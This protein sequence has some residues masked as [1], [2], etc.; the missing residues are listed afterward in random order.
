MKYN[1]ER[2]INE[3]ISTRAI[4][5]VASSYDKESRS[6]LCVAATEN[7]VLVPDYER[8][9]MVNEVLL[10]DGLSLPENRA[11]VPFLDT[12]N[13]WSVGAVLGSARDWKKENGQAVCRPY[14]TST[15]EGRDLETKVTEGHV[16]DVSIGFQVNE[17]VWIEEKTTVTL[18]GRSFTGPL[19]VVTKSTV[20]ELSAVPIG[21]DVFATIRSERAAQLGLPEDSS[22]EQI[23]EFI[24]NNRNNS[25][26][27]PQQFR[28]DASM[29]EELKKLQEQL[30]LANEKLAALE[31]DSKTNRENAEKAQRELADATEIMATAARMSMVPGIY[32]MAKKAIEEKRSAKDFYS[33]VLGKVA[34]N[35][36]AT[37]TNDGAGRTIITLDSYNRPWKRRAVAYLHYLVAAKRGVQEKAQQ[38][39]SQFDEM[40]NAMTD[41][42]KQDELRETYELI[43]KS[44]LSEGQQH[45]LMSSL[46]DGAGKYLVP[47]PMLAEIFILVEQWGVARRYFRPIPMTSET[48]KLDSLVTHA[49]AYWV[50]QGNNITGTD[51]AFGQG[52]LTVRKIAAI[53]A[54]TNELSEDAAIALLPVV[55]ESFA[56]GIF[57]LE[58]LAGFIGDGTS[59]YGSFTGLINF[60]GNVV[61]MD[62]GKT[63]FADA[64]ADDFKALRDAVNINH[65]KGAYFW[66]SPDVVSN[67]EG[68]KD[69]QQRYIY[70]EPSAGLP[71]MLWGYPI[72]DS[73]G[74]NALTQTSAA[75]TKFAAFGNPKHMLMGMKREIEILASREGILNSAADAITFNALQADGEILR[76]TERV[77]FQGV[78]ST[79][80]SVLKTA[81][82]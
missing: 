47:T 69:G 62:A 24:K 66:L 54:W 10:M 29:E 1:F 32:D 60:A 5:V 36:A 34:N 2:L 59:T 53:G 12:H 48:L 17:S 75:A 81:T 58:D 25:K 20:R 33:D 28:K 37:P 31:G 79:A 41:Q 57:E 77:G 23:R 72:A 14:L 61:T 22:D 56:Q 30:R 70:R 44:G 63:A 27:L 52:T 42:Q 6:F 46:T 71:A 4:P 40:R 38:Y 50:T 26:S 11:Q 43:T 82:T 64:N 18:N 49:T 45:R 9:E 65:R 8:W 76:M 15:E 39:R 73:V 7:P 3:H 74:I 67:L 13:R 80:L 19:K 16:T 21:A 78:L 35:V 51:L 68:L 55:Y